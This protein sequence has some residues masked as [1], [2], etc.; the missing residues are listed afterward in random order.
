LH[1][2]LPWSLVPIAVRTAIVVFA[3]VAGLRIVGRRDVGGLNMIDLVMVLLLGNAV[4]NAITSGS[5]ALVVGVVSAGTLLII[6][7][8]LGIVFVREPWLEGQ[9]FGEPVVLASNGRLDTWA[10]RREGI[11]EDEV[12]TAAR[13]QG[14]GDLSQVRLAVLEDDGTISIIPR[15]REEG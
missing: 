1:T 13:E 5:G 11:D 8:V 4:Q 3:L 6:D 7:Q 9:L 14:V 2:P 12:L 10:M 15:E